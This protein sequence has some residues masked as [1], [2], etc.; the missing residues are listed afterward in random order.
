MSEEI[1][2]LIDS[3]RAAKKA[4]EDVDKSYKKLQDD[5]RTFL[6]DSGLKEFDGVEIQRVMSFDY[7]LLHLEH[8]DLFERYI[9]RYEKMAYKDSW[10]SEKLKKEFQEKYPDI[11]NDKDYRTE[12][13]A[14]LKGV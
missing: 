5:V 8:P 7:E 10:K 11:W 1:Q 2:K 13:T 14:R 12:K 9:D 6:I 4:K 3:L